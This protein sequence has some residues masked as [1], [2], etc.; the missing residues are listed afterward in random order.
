MFRQN[1]EVGLTPSQVTHVG[2]VIML[3]G[4]WISNQ[5]GPTKEA[6]VTFGAEGNA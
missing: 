1:Y 5:N 3:E 4:W 6:G 2:K